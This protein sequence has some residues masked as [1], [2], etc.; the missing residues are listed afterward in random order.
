MERLIFVLTVYYPC[1]MYLKMTLA[2]GRLPYIN[3]KTRK[4]R[5][6]SHIVKIT[7]HARITKLSANSQPGIVLAGKRIMTAIGEVNGNND[8]T[9]DSTLSGCVTMK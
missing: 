2:E 3:R 7:E 5:D 4:M 6:D 9:L 8:R 1:L